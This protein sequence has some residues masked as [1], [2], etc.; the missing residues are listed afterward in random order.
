[1][2]MSD[3]RGWSRLAVEAT[4]GV[5]D[6]VEELHR[7]VT[8]LPA[9]G[10][11]NP[12]RRERM[13]GITGFVYRTIRR[14]TQWIGNGIDGALGRLQPLLL[15]NPADRPSPTSPNRDSLPRDAL[16]A[17]L[18][19]VL[20][21]HLEASGNPL[22]IPMQFRREGRPLDPAQ[23]QGGRVLLL[24]HGL[25]RS[26]LQHRRK[27][28]DH[29][30]RLA[31]E[32]GYSPV[33]L[34]YNSGRSIATNG[35][36]L[37]ER[38]EAFLRTWPVPVTELVVVAH[39][40]GGLLMRSACRVAEDAGLAWRE[41]LQKIVFLGT[42]HH[43]APLERGGNWVTLALDS[44]SY[45]AA[46][47]R[48]SRIRSAGIVDLRFGELTDV[49]GKVARRS[50]PRTPV[51]LPRSVACFAIAASLASGPRPSG[52][53][54]ARA[55]LGDGL[56]PVTSALGDDADPARALAIPPHRRFIGYGMSHLDLLDRGVVYEQIRT[57]LAE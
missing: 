54:A 22:A 28:H 8:N 46:F 26:D 45:T 50:R 35:R 5:T 4:L 48:L 42:P 56:V 39:S 3:L 9:V 44:T 53:A 27:G 41:R 10:G 52:G 7:S 51:P 25:C 13:R 11:P 14:I 31:E 29:G 6:L 36:E 33:Y 18:N 23:E 24:V 17:A 19:G 30:A 37:A 38:L 47:A 34:H 2:Q 15:A 32:L 43:G 1:M 49:A 57:W 12:E 55:L 21:D 20:G 40:M 16:L